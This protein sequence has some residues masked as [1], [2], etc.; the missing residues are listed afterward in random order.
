MD[1]LIETVIVS[2]WNFSLADET[3]KVGHQIQQSCTGS[4][5]TGRCS[6]GNISAPIFSLSVR[7]SLESILVVIK[8]GYVL[9]EIKSGHIWVDINSRHRH[10]D[11]APS[12]TR[13]AEISR[14]SLSERAGTTVAGAGR[15]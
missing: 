10:I 4:K 3:E 2:S 5:V 1:G 8:S 12:I 13:I 14:T 6:V 9:V 7:S 11:E 15:C